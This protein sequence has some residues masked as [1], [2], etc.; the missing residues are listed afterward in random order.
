M[1][2]PRLFQRVAVVEH[3]RAVEKQHVLIGKRQVFAYLAAGQVAD[4]RQCDFGV[5]GNQQ[6][7]QRTAEGV[8]EDHQLPVCFRLGVLDG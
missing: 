2:Y 6:G 7:G 1:R 5:A 3:R 8:P 4:V